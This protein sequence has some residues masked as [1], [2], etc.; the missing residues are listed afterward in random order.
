MT[1]LV[2]PLMGR[3]TDGDKV[4][5]DRVLLALQRVE[6]SSTFVQARIVI[7]R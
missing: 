6:V 1:G 5:L 7:L 4:E 2:N 3:F